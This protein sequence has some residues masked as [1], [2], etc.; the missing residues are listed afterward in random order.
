MLEDFKG[1]P[2]VAP[3]IRGAKLVEHSGHMV[4]EGGYD[5]IPKYVLS[6]IHI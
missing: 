5:M 1:H 3:I 2:A 6:L 4:P